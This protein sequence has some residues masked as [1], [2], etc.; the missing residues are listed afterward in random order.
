MICKYLKGMVDQRKGEES[1]KVRDNDGLLG[2]GM[3]FASLTFWILLA[4]STSK[5]VDQILL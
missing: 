3:D 5:L 4:D 2:E 1:Y